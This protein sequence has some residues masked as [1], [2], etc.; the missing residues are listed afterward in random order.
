MLA[1]P[2]KLLE[3]VPMPA[4]VPARDAEA[5]DPD[6]AVAEMPPHAAENNVTRITENAFFI[7]TTSCGPE[8]EITAII[9]DTGARSWVVEAVPTADGIAEPLAWARLG[10]AIGTY[11][12][13]IQ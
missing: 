13:M 8:H 6:G 3:S 12:A 5:I 1:P 9:G 7:L 4:H 2:L 11:E 10:R